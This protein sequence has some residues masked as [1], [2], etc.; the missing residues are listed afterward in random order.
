MIKTQF[1]GTDGANDL[2]LAALYSFQTLRQ[3]LTGRLTQLFVR[4]FQYHRPK[5]AISMG[6]PAQN[7]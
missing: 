4:E 7:D 5:L 2:R 3:S 6:L 1:K